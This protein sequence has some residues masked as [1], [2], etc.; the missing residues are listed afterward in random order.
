MQKYRN[1][2]LIADN[3]KLKNFDLQAYINKYKFIVAP[4]KFE[5][6]DILV[7]MGGDGSLL[8]NM[9]KYIDLNIPFFGFNMGS[10]GF[11]MNPFDSEDLHQKFEESYSNILYPLQ[12]KIIDSHQ[13]EYK[14]LAI[15]E[16][17]VWRKTNQAAKIEISINNIIRLEE[18]IADGVMVSTPAGSTAYNLSAG[19]PI[20]PLDSNILSLTSIC[21]FR[22][23]RWHGALLSHNS[24]ISFKIHEPE[25]RPVNAVADFYE[26]FDVHEIKI[27]EY[28]KKPIK[29]LFDKNHTLEDRIIKE[30]FAS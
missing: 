20:L 28:R 2:G 14:R 8:H 17:S 10:I 1:I 9:H 13:Q 19:G 11:L 18:L 15:N 16:V 23:R 24:E 27:K 12:M 30:Q 7:V 29:L 22:P 26:Y 21:P 25:K 6:C 5:E 3:I 4:E